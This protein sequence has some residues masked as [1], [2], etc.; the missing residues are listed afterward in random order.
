M[1]SADLIR[2]SVLESPSSSTSLTLSRINLQT[3]ADPA[4]VT[5]I[6]L[7]SIALCTSRAFVDV[8]NES[9]FT[10]HFVVSH[11][12]VCRESIEPAQTNVHSDP[13]I[14]LA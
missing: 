3:S 7:I 14:Y 12:R 1:L 6:I 13:L 11:V 9:M 2:Q 8:N 4:F 5:G 10:F